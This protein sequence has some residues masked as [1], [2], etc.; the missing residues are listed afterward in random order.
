MAE[1]QR[2]LIFRCFNCHKDTMIM[3]NVP[4]QLAMHRKK[5]AVVHYC[6]HCN[7]PNKLEV[8]DNIDVHEFILGQDKELLGYQEGI[9]ILQGEQAL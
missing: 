3:V 2:Q 6:E 4:R 1:K 9:P 5:V 7:R 8:G